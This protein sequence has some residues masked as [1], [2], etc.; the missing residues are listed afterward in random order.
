MYLISLPVFYSC[1]RPPQGQNRSELNIQARQEGFVVCTW[2]SEKDCKRKQLKFL[3]QFC[4]HERSY[5]YFLRVEAWCLSKYTQLHP[6]LLYRAWKFYFAIY[7]RQIVRPVFERSVN[8]HV[9]QLKR[10]LNEG[11]QLGERN[12]KTGN[13]KLSA[14]SLNRNIYLYSYECNYWFCCDE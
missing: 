9:V 3:A 7:A 1:W 11:S 10:D 6:W 14:H 5:M 2:V 12:L 13:R 8:W 4:Q